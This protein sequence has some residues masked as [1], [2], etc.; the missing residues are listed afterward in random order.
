MNQ[1]EIYIQDYENLQNL[2][3]DI[4]NSAW[5][6]ILLSKKENHGIYRFKLANKLP[7]IS[8]STQIVWELH[9]SFLEP[10]A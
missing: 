3:K 8:S 7:K 1:Y 4:R 6:L 9:G 10:I 2:M 5:C